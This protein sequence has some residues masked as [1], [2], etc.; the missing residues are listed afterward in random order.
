MKN[1]DILLSFVD[2]FTKIGGHLSLDLSHRLANKKLKFVVCV[3][4]TWFICSLKS[5]KVGYFAQ[6]CR[7]F[8]KLGGHL[9]LEIEIF[10][11]CVRQLVHLFTEE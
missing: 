8:S 6:F 9:P 2:I 11:L 1:W 3:S 7:Y 10:C 4:V 5:E